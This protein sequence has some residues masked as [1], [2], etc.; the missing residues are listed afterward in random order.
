MGKLFTDTPFPTFVR[1]L[2]APLYNRFDCNNIW[3]IICITELSDSIDF[4]S[5]NLLINIY[6]VLLSVI[7]VGCCLNGSYV[8]R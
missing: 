5:F 4:R 3:R 6:T 1:Y 2:E 8:L 7:N